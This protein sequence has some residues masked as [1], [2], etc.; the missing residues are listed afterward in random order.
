MLEAFIAQFYDDKP[1]PPFLLL[2]HD[3]PESEL[4]AE[5]LA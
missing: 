1:P 2:S 3:L 5:A 4:V